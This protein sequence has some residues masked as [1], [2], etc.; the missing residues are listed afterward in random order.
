MGL[1]DLGSHCQRLYR[2]WL[3]A[4]GGDSLPGRGGDDGGFHFFISFDDVAG[5]PG[6]YSG[7]LVVRAPRLLNVSFDR[8]QIKLKLAELA[9][10]GV[11]VGT[12]SWKYPGWREML[13][14]DARYVYRGKFAESRFEK[15]CLTE[16]AGIFKTVCVDAAYYKFPDEKYLGEMAVQVPKDFQFAFKVTDVITLKRFG[17]LPRFGQRAGMANQHYLDAGLFANAFLRPCEPFRDSIGLLVFE[18]SRFYSTD[19]EHGRDF[20]ADLDRFLR[21]IPK[22]WP[23]AVEMRNKHWL[24]PEYFNCLARHGV[25]HVYNSWE[26]MPSVAEQIAMPRSE[27]NPDLIAARFLLKPGRK[28]EDAVKMFKPYTEAREKNEEVRAAGRQLIRK[29]LA[30]AEKKKTFIYV[31]NRLEGNALET[32]QAMLEPVG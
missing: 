13:Y 24:Q 17:N 28:Y 2:V 29:G 4:A 8:E 26:A 25:T 22:G 19:Y 20:L 10:Q 32:I 3:E 11:Y 27:T 12:S 15:H 9:A 6:N 21:D 5:V 31:N 18:F 14:D 30:A 7:G 23:Y 1:D 16:Y